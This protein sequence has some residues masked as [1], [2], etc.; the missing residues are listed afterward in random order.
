MQRPFTK[1]LYVMAPIKYLEALSAA[2][3]AEVRVR[4]ADHELDELVDVRLV[5]GLGQFTLKVDSLPSKGAWSRGKHLIIWSLI[6]LAIQPA[7]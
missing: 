5:V 2:V 4:A 1:S 7:A 3:R 6:Q